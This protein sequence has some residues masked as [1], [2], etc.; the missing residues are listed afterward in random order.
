M[1][2]KTNKQTKLKTNKSQRNTTYQ[3][4][5]KEPSPPFKNT[6]H[7]SALDWGSSPNFDFNNKRTQGNS[8][9]TFISPE[10]IKKPRFSDNFR[11]IRSY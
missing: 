1:T 6:I 4:R 8:L 9:I 3:N 7:I 10:I 5:L 2:N 11:G